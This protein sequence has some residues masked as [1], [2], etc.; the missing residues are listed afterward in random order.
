MNQPEII[1]PRLILKAITPQLIRDIFNS[2]SKQEI[3]EYF[4]FDESGYEHY[5]NMHEKGM[6]THR[7]SL[8]YFLLMDKESNQPIGECGFHSWN[9]PHR[10]AELFYLLRQDQYKQKGLMTEAL[11]FVLD[12]G[13]KDLNLHRVE[14]LVA[15]TNEPS[16]RILNH[17]GFKFEGIRREDYNTNGKNENSACYSLLS[18]EWAG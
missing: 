14:A 5:R 1:T 11:R 12:Y 6:E 9:V 17:Y 15:D 10:R 3:Q 16:I 13:F 18:H 4:G 7:F 2:K 8:F